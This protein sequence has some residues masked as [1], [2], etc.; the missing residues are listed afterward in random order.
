MK[1]YKIKWSIWAFSKSI[2][3]PIQNIQGFLKSTALPSIAT[4]WLATNAE[5]ALAAGGVIWIIDI[6]LH[7]TYL[8]EI[9]PS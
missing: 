7:F 3:Q 1:K 5:I 6:I 2:P 9:K 4:T 8:E